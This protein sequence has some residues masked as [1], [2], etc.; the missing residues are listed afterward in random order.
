MAEKIKN[1]FFTDGNDALI[2]FVCR[3]MSVGFS[4]CLSYGR[5][6]GGPAPGESHRN[7]IGGEESNGRWQEKPSLSLQFEF[8]MCLNNKSVSVRRGARPTK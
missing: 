8:N 6:P 1:I 5:L 7:K 3:R 4:I 2:L